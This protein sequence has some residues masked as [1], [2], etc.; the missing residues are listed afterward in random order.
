MS[1]PDDELHR[2][3]D[4]LP[5]SLRD[6]ARRRLQELLETADGE[7]PGEPS[8]SGQGILELAASMEGPDDLSVRHDDPLDGAS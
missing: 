3:V 1:I 5:E 4:R 8:W 2:M 7:E 6:E